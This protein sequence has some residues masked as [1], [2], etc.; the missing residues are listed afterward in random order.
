MMRAALGSVS[1]ACAFNLKL[2][3]IGKTV[4]HVTDDR[5]GVGV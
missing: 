3:R 4:S 5:L 1:H 2:N